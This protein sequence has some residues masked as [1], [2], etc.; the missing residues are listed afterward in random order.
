MTWAEEE[1]LDRRHDERGVGGD[2]IEALAFHRLEQVAQTPFHRIESVEGGVHAGELKR[3]GVQ[4]GAN[5]DLG[6]LGIRESDR[7]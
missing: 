6:L 5:D 7:T 1:F 3:A 2:E 4:V